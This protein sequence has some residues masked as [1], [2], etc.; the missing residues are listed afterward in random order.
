MFEQQSVG[1]LLGCSSCDISD[2]Q[3]TIKSNVMGMSLQKM[4]GGGPK[5]KFKLSSN[6]E[7]NQGSDV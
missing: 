7:I 4:A 1:L 3:N 6:S 5:K 2:G